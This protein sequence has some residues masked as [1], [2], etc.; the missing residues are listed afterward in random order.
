[1]FVGLTF[2]AC[3]PF[4]GTHSSSFSAIMGLLIPSPAVRYVDSVGRR[5]LLI[6]GVSFAFLATSVGSA[7][8]VAA[9]PI[10]AFA[11]GGTGMSISLFVLAGSS[12]AFDHSSSH[13][14]WGPLCIVSVLSFVAFFSFRP[15]LY[16]STLVRHVL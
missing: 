2:V 13:S 12:Y 16:T 6:A 1:M 4:A 15:A 3:T 14:T 7:A 10:I 5:V 9:V 11:A 8:C